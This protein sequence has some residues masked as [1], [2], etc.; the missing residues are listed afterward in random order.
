[1]TGIAGLRCAC[2]SAAILAI[3]P[4]LEPLRRGAVDIVTRSDPLIA[5]GAPD[6]AWCAVCWRRAFAGPPAAPVRRARRKA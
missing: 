3:R 4:G 5:R 2:G 6:A 1:V